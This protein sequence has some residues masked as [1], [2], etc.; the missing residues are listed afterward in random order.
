MHGGKDLKKKWSTKDVLE[1]PRKLV[2]DGQQ[3]GFLQCQRSTPETLVVPHPLCTSFWLLPKMV[4][5][6]YEMHIQPHPL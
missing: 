6:D 1:E 5:F 2:I 4:T 3:Q